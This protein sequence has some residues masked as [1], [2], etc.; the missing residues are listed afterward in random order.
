V[1]LPLPPQ[2]MSLLSHTTLDDSHF[3]TPPLT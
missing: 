3:I 2:K 1:S